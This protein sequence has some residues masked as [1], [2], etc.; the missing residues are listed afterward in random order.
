MNYWKLSILLGFIIL[1]GVVGFWCSLNNFKSR[2]IDSTS[3]LIISNESLPMTA[4]IISPQGVNI[5][6]RVANTDK[7]RELGLSYFKTLAKN[8]G[9]LFSF[10][11]LGIYPFWMKDMNFP[12]D[13]IWIDENSIIVDRVISVDPSSYPNSF[14][15]QH[16]A[17]YVL[18]IPA[19]TADQYGLIVG[20]SVIIQR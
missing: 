16:A 6:V 12:L 5:Q 18:E 9:M 3:A 17:Q 14:I 13:I 20:A 8:E 19:G 11:Q 4:V 2:E 1:F 7:T 15:P 10:P